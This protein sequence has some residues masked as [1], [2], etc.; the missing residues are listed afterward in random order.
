MPT[1]IL[2][3]NSLSMLLPGSGDDKEASTRRE[4]AAG[5]LF[6]FLDQLSTVCPLEQ[7]ALL[8]FSSTCNTVVGFTRDY[9]AIKAGITSLTTGDKTLLRMGVRSAGTSAG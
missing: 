6:A 2:L 5:A 9:N 4:I 8:Q 1:L 3:D 7:V